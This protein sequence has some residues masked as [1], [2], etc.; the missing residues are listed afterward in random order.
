M[1]QRTL[2]PWDPATF[3]G[4]S[5]VTFGPL[6]WRR[7]VNERLFRDHP[8]ASEACKAH[9]EAYYYGG[10]EQDR[11]EADQAL[12]Q[13]WAEVGVPWLTRT[14]GYRAIRLF[15]GPDRRTPGVSWAFG[16]EFFQYSDEPAVP[17]PP[18]DEDPAG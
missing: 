15:G 14:L 10:S 8:G 12:L 7:R 1:S 5:A 6:A 4:C 11:R 2:P 17:E 3:D 13:A 18:T 16:D 9:D